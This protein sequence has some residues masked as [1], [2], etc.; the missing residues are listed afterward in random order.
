VCRVLDGAFRIRDAGHLSPLFAGVPHSPIRQ[1]RGAVAPIR[2]AVALGEGRQLW[3]RLA[4]LQITGG[5]KLR[6]ALD[7]GIPV[8]LLCNKTMEA[9]ILR[10]VR[11]MVMQVRVHS[12]QGEVPLL[13]QSRLVFL[14]ELLLV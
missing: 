9:D 6:V 11:L 7:M 1:L 2:W 4:R 3:C 12:D 5:S 10:R 14:E 13:R 8:L